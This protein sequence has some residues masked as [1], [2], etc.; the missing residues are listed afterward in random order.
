MYQLY[1]YH[2]QVVGE[3]TSLRILCSIVTYVL[4]ADSVY[5]L[6]LLCLDVPYL[7]VICNPNLHHALDKM[8]LFS[9]EE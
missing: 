3:K 5:I 2:A 7:L 9:I 6:N 8:D 1:M 4:Y